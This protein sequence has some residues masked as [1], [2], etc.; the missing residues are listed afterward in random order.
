MMR[1]VVSDSLNMNYIPR[2]DAAI[3]YDQCRM[4]CADKVKIETNLPQIK[5]NLYYK[6]N[7]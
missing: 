4:P 2:V 1:I 7:N 6:T 3:V 5:V